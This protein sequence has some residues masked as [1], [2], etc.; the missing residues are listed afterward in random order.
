MNYI[1]LERKF[2]VNQ[3]N[4]LQ[5]LHKLP[6][7]DLR[8]NRKKFV[9]IGRFINLNMLISL[10]VQRVVFFYRFYQSKVT[11]FNNNSGLQNNIK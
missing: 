7:F 9:R 3:E 4:L 11:G 8:E 5:L 2:T 1:R 6:M 10:L